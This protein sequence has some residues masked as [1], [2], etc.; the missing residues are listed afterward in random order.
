MLN[1]ITVF[2]LRCIYNLDLICAQKNQFLKIIKLTD[3]EKNPFLQPYYPAYFALVS[4][5]VQMF[6]DAA[7]PKNLTRENKQIMKFGL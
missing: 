7:V 4:P 3:D 6:P 2:K 5:E 1:Q